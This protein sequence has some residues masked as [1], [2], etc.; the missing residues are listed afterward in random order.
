M[1]AAEGCVSTPLVYAHA[2]KAQA[3][4]ALREAY[5]LGAGLVTLYRV[6]PGR[7]KSSGSWEHDRPPIFRVS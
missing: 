4:H 7:P 3:I 1:G 6:A 2:Q 5:Q